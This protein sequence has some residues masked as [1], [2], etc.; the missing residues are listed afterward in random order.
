MILLN[1]LVQGEDSI[2]ERVPTQRLVFLVKH[3]IQCFQSGL[4]LPGL[5][6]ET[7][8]L[9]TSVLPHICE[10]Y[11]S[12]W[13]DMLEMLISLWNG[14]LTGDDSLPVLHSSLRL[15]ACLR[16]LASSESNDDLEDAWKESNKNLS[17]HLI[18]N[19]GQFGK[20]INT[21]NISIVIN[22][23]TLN[24]DS[25]HTLHQ[26][27]SITADLLARQI[28]TVDVDCIDDVN[29]LFPLLPVQNWGVQRAAYDILHRYIPK[30]QEQI[31][32]DQALSKSAARLPDELLSLLIEAPKTETFSGPS[33]GDSQWMELRCYLLSWKVVFD[34][35]TNSVT[36]SLNTLRWKSIGTDCFVH[37]SLSP[38]K[39][40]TLLI[41]RRMLALSHYSSLRLTSS[42]IL[43]GKPSMRPSSTYPHL[44]LTRQIQPRGKQSGSL[45]ISITYV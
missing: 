7:L 3:L 29:S 2:V 35:F 39:K 14:D 34:H 21:S 45:C 43:L 8:K 16:S 6:S 27:R 17:T 40:T 36:L 18:A 44:N 30:A 38:S 9:L 10:I 22:L 24:I 19:L 25:S 1:I 15:F 31:S 23:L 11:G 12:H 5:A 41:S 20:G 13:T 26:P 42:N 4:E 28:S 33:V 37:L 32:F